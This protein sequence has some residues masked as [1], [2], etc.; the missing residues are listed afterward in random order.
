MV[1]CCSKSADFNVLPTIY[2]FQSAAI[3]SCRCILRENFCQP[4]PS[5]WITFEEI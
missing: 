5:S 4:E 3:L 2:L 1:L